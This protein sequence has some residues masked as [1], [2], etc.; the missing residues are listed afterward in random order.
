[1]APS[2][3]IVGYLFQIAGMLLMFYSFVMLVIGIQ[4]ITGSVTGS[5]GQ[6]AGLHPSA[7]QQNCTDT[8]V[9][10][11]A[12]DDLSTSEGLNSALERRITEFVK[13]LVAGLVLLFIGVGIRAGGEIGGFLAK[14]KSGKQKEKVLV[15]M[16]WS[17]LR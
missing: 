2:V 15:G 5:I 12:C 16:R 14:L 17:H 13:W 11:G 1:M 7:Q 9:E 3:K 10:G 8:E 6:S 4:G